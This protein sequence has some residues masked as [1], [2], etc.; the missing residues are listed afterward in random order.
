LVQQPS[1]QCAAGKNVAYSYSYLFAYGIDLPAGARTLTL[2]KNPNVRILAISVAN[3]D[4]EAKPLE[5]LYDVLPFPNAGAPDFTL[6][7][8]GKVLSR[9]AAPRQPGSSFFREAI[10]TAE[11]SSPLSIF[12]LASPQNSILLRKR[13]TPS[14]SPISAAETAAPTISDFQ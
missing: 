9:R 4:T 13:R 8:S 1:S 2:P 3:E 5:P 11:L 14:P 10:L 7:T 12:P 6:S